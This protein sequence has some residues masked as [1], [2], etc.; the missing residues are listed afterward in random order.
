MSNLG[1]YQDL[2]TEAKKHGGPEPYLDYLEGNAKQ[3]GR[4]EG[5]LIG[6]GIALVIGAVS[7]AIKK[8]VDYY[9]SRKEAK[10][11]ASIARQEL[12]ANMEQC[13]AD[14]ESEEPIRETEG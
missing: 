3:E 1:G 6:A 9:K 5:A 13:E 11:L 2:T 4:E 8:G 14:E 12:L 7:F 10:L